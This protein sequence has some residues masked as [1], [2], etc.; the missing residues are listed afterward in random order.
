MSKVKVALDKQEPTIMV[1]F[2]AEHN[3]R[4]ELVGWQHG[5]PV[6][7]LQGIDVLIQ[8]EIHRWAARFVRADAAARSKSDEANATA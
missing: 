5:I 2:D 7:K 6:S 1:R 4:V 8:Q 3:P